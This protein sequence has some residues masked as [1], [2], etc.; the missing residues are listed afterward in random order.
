MISVV[1]KHKRSERLEIKSLSRTSAGNI[2]RVIAPAT[3][4]IAALAFYETLYGYA[5]HLAVA[6]TKF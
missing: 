1:D 5:D 4:D 2:N 3:T 6:Q